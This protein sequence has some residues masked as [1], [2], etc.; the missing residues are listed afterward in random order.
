[1]SLRR[2]VNQPSR[3]RR[4]P[5]RTGRHAE[6]LEA[7]H[8]LSTNISPVEQLLVELL[9]S[10]RAN[11]TVAAIEAGLT[12]LNQDLEPGTI[13][14]APK[15]PLA[16]HQLLANAAGGHSSDMFQRNFFDH[17]DPDGVGPR[18]RAL[19]AGYTTLPLGEN[20]AFQESQP[21]PT[22]DVVV[23]L[24][25][26]LIRSPSHRTAI[27]SPAFDEIG[28]GI[29]SG[30][31]AGETRARYYITEMF[32]G[33]S[34]DVYL[35]G[36]AFADVVRV[37][38]D[39]DVGEG[40]GSVAI[41]AQSG[42]GATLSES[43]G[44]AGGYALPMPAGT[45]TV[46]ATGPGLPAPV[47]G[48]VAVGTQNVKLDIS[49]RPAA[50]N[51]VV[52]QAYRWLLDRAP[53]PVERTN[54]VAAA[55]QFSSEHVLGS[56][57]SSAEYFALAGNDL[58]TF[59]ARA[60]RE[61]LGRE[62]GPAE[63]AGW[64]GAL[65]SGLPRSGFAAA[66]VAGPEFREA[67]LAT[68]NDFRPLIG[69]L[70]AG[71]DALGW[72]LAGNERQG[73]LSGLY[74]DLMGREGSSR[75]ILSWTRDLAAGLSPADVVSRFLQSTEY[76]QRQVR[77]L[78]ADILGRAPGPSEL[79]EWVGQ[80]RSGLTVVAAQSRFYASGEF[81]TVAGGTTQG[82]VSQ[83]YQNILNRTASTAEL[84][85]WTLPIDTGSLSRSQAALAFLNG[86]EYRR[87]AVDGL[88]R[89]W[90]GRSLDATGWAHWS[91]VLAAGTPIEGVVRGIVLS[92]E[93]LTRNR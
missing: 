44:P 75:E 45:Y 90:L 30:I 53:S 84:S 81:L 40:L 7:R 80:L 35:T 68:A 63:V 1:M 4:L 74:R 77:S 6:R 71:E 2:F 26:G 57:L 46:L 59:V 56:I 16:P 9:N 10:A 11:P 47:L 83:L 65:A 87:M 34:R 24:H 69:R 89:D 25:A 86:V 54:W 85:L 15:Q 48:E 20:L 70:A 8:L 79:S 14:P 38:G 22:V 41:V 21:L 32:G 49:P 36:V 64:T 93:Y 33:N 43:T 31:P 92:N 42:A 18:E 23:E 52:E 27:F 51:Q 60:Y 62:A 17:V 72:L 78:Y 12:N 28:T 37:D 88:Y 76:A 19:D 61:L 5:R 58:A 82:F 55:R 73:W 50:A 29:V 39:Y 66:V 13:S 3:Q 67:L 91:A